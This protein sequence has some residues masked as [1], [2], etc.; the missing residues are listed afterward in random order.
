MCPIDTY[1]RT[2]AVA[3]SANLL[4]AESLA[5]VLDGRL[6]NGVDVAGLVLGEPRGEIDVARLHS[7]DTDLVTLEQIRDESE[8][9]IVGELVG[10]EL[11]V[12]EKTEDIGQKDDGLLG[13]LVVLGRDDV[14][15]D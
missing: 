2:E 10:Q 12:R 14:G 7:L 9:T 11:G 5:R 13:G 6:H 15:V 3:H 1:L 4:H 8:V